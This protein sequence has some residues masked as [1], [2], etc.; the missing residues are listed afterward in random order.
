MPLQQITLGNGFV[1][2]VLWMTTETLGTHRKRTTKD[3]EVGTPS[4]FVCQLPRTNADGQRP[5]IFYTNGYETKLW[6]INSTVPRR[7]HGYQRRITVADRKE[8]R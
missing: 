5:V 4:L 1:D 3:I 2:Y 8:Q 6:M 7:V